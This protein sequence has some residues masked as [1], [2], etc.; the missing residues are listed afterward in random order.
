MS[1]SPVLRLASQS[2]RRRELLAQIGVPHAVAVPDVDE[3]ARAGETVTAYVE[4]LACAKAEAIWRRLQDLPVLG[5]DTT[6]VLD[7]RSL[8]KPRD[9]AEGLLMLR[10]LAGREHQVL[11]SVALVTVAGTRC[12]TSC[13]TVRMRS[14]TDQERDRYWDTG[15]PC[16]KAGAYAIQGLGAIFIESLQGSYSGVM[17]LPLFETAQ[18]L[19]AARVPCWSAS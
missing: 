2:P 4:R 16:D 12:V 1:L 3:G 5:A 11:T 9:R 17:G 10:A 8:G 7:G 15:E 18:L 19:A 6:V 13:S 14:S